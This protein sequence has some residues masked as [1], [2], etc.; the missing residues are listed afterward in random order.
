MTFYSGSINSTTPNTD[1]M[2]V[3]NTNIAAHAAWEFVE[4]VTGTPSTR[5]TDVY[6]CLG[7]SNS[8]GVDFYVG[9][10]RSATAGAAWGFV[11]GEGWDSGTKKF[12]NPG[13]RCAY[14]TALTI[15]TDLSYG[16]D[17]HAANETTLVAATDGFLR[18]A[19]M[20]LVDSGI[21]YAAST[22]Y[23]WY[24]SVTNDRIVFTSTS[25]SGTVGLY[26][27]LYDSFHSTSLDPFPLYCGAL[28]ASPHATSF[29]DVSR[30]STVRENGCAT[31]DS[32]SGSRTQALATSVSVHP[33]TWTGAGSNL[34]TT[35][36]TK[37]PI[38]NKW[39]PSRVMLV[40]IGHAGAIKG[41]LK[42][43]VLMLNLG[44]T[45]EVYG[46]TVTIDGVAYRFCGSGPGIAGSSPTS[47]GN[48]SVIVSYWVSESA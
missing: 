21:N 47:S 44:E 31:R 4:T 10:C 15:E 35:T 22:A 2:T 29:R 8:F 26:V 11:I 12:T 45:S 27:G 1:I 48:G 40:S 30:S 38:S 3:L 46:D 37:E 42:S 5:V 19:G 32:G 14:N 33:W 36:L 16:T 34:A 18:A 23:T 43:D 20:A 7:T 39:W 25:N 28:S 17:R 13:V 24:L 6:K 9:V 41:L